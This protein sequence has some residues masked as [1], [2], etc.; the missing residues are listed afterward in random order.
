MAKKTSF[1]V[2]TSGTT[3]FPSSARFTTAVKMACSS[4]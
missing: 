3:R 1:E 2:S 4:G